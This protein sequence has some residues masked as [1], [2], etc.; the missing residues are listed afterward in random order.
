M[1]GGKKKKREKADLL[2]QVCENNLGQGQSEETGVVSW[3]RTINLGYLLCT[4]CKSIHDKKK[5]VL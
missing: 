5:N 2:L 4:F 1:V 3:H